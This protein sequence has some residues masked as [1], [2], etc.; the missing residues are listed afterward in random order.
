MF[1]G[2]VTLPAGRYVAHYVSDGS[3]A[4][5]AWN[6]ARPFDAPAWGLRIEPGP[7]VDDAS[8][9]LL[10]DEELARSGD[11]LVRIAY[12]GDDERVRRRF[13]LD[14]PE[15]VEIRAVGEGSSGEMHDYGFLR[16]N[17]SGRMVWEMD[18]D[19]TRHAGG[20]DKNRMVTR[21]VRLEP[22]AYEAVY[23]SD[24]SHS[25]RGWNAEGPRDPTGW[26]LT[27]RRIDP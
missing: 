2:F 11:L 12:V 1:D 3:H 6:S 27:V 10:D 5:G 9:R 23:V 17:D 15:T 18:Y 16:E 21:R 20:A 7:G 8:V 24:G 4:A 14:R 19:D 26:G 25:F 22:G 13:T